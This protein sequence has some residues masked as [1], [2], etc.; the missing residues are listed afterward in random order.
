MFQRAIQ[1]NAI[2]LQEDLHLFLSWV[3]FSD[4]FSRSQIRV[5]RR[6]RLVRA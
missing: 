6:A 1:E 5:S 4:V 3:S 2:T